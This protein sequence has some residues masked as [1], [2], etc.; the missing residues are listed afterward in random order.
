[1]AKQDKGK[2]QLNKGKDHS[3]DISKGGKRKFDL[4]K[5]DDEPIV[6]SSPASSPQDSPKLGDPVYDTQSVPAPHRKNN[7]K[8]LWIILAII[9]LVILIWVL[10][11]GKTSDSQP[12]EE[13]ESIE[14]TSVPSTQEN[15]SPTIENDSLKDEATGAT[16]DINSEAP[17]NQTTP[18]GKSDA[19]NPASSQA[20]NSA[21]PEK[22]SSITPTDVETEALKVV[23]GDYG[24]GAERKNR[25]GDR[26]NAIQ[27]RVNELKREG[28]F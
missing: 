4:S 6:S 23:R 5:E 11:L 20:T 1:M 12:K 16:E 10:F 17:T 27:K 15:D 21:V 8:W 13:K 25:L 19:N 24:N 26:Y 14:A 9:V 22:S 18:A 3:F 2:F 28:R 7:G